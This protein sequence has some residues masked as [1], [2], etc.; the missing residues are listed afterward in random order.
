M[1]E[2]EN[3]EFRFNGKK[4]LRYGSRLCVPDD[5]GLKGDIMRE[6]YNARY[7]IHHGA[8]KMYQALKKVYWW[9]SIKKET[10]QFVSAYEVC[11]R[12]KLQH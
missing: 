3:P 7:S 6:A 4:V 2:G 10:V 9:P 5:I 1:Q 8:T 11:Q 12:V